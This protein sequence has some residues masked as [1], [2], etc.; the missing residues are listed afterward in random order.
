MS[1]TGSPVISRSRN[2]TRPPSGRTT[3]LMALKSVVLPQPFGPI[4]PRLA[5]VASDRST[6]PSDST[7]PKRTV[8]PS[9]CN[10]ID[11]PFA[12]GG[13]AMHG[14]LVEQAARPHDQQHGNQP[15]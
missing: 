8:N 4:R 10:S 11:Q 14:A 12:E 15:A 9:S 3:P 6:A 5:P 7:P 13:K 1:Y 2:R